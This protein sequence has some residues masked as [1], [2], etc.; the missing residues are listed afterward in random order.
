MLPPLTGLESLLPNSLEVDATLFVSKESK[1]INRITIT[2]II[3]EW[4]LIPSILSIAQATCKY[5]V[6]EPVNDASVSLQLDAVATVGKSI[7]LICK[8]YYPA[9]Y[10][11]L[12]LDE[13]TPIYLNN[14]IAAF[15]SDK[16]GFVEEL[17]ITQLNGEY[18]K[19][20]GYLAF[21]IA[22]AKSTNLKA[23]D[24]FGFQLN[25]ISLSISGNATYSFKMAAS[26]TY[27]FTKAASKTLLFNGSAVYSGGWVFSLQEAGDV[28][29]KDIAT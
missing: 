15:T 18:N 27:T 26:F 25:N 29:L 17:A 21:N 4:E 8:A 9:G 2:T 24:S 28:S 1:S 14:L 13:S 12:G 20:S 3:G 6:F 11:Y 16:L 7:N 22:I 19:H 23:S 5:K 10:F